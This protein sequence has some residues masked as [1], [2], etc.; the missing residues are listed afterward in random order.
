M[1]TELLD[2]YSYLH[3]AVGVVAYFIG[4]SL[5]LTTGLHI[6]FEYVENTETGI[7]FI[8]KHLS[9]FWPGGKDYPD[10][11]A[12]RVGDTLST[13]VGWITAYLLDQYGKEKGWYLARP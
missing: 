9:W 8:N 11:T 3:L 10:S 5:P 4:F 2:Q 12:N 13:I 6:V 1:G 7:N